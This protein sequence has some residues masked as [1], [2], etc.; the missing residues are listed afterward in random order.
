MHF[1]IKFGFEPVVEHGCLNGLRKARLNAFAGHPV[2]QASRPGVFRDGVRA[3]LGK[4]QR[5]DGSKGD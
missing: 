3:V 5:R 1:L 2:F 4:G